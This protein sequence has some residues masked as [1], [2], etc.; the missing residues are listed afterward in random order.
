MTTAWVQQKTSL[1]SMVIIHVASRLL[2]SVIRLLIGNEDPALNSVSKSVPDLG[3]WGE[4]RRLCE[5][6]L[7]KASLEYMGFSVRAAVSH[8]RIEGSVFSDPCLIT[9]INNWY[10]LLEYFKLLSW[11]MLINI[12]LILIHPFIHLFNKCLLNYFYVW[13]IEI[14]PQESE[15]KKKIFSKELLIYPED[16][17]QLL[18]TKGHRGPE[19]WLG[20]MCQKPGWIREQV[21][22]HLQAMVTGARE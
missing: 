17:D 15:K 1:S 8:T 5:V 16:S 14:R 12:Y 11:Y 9:T 2:L 19:P 3:C 6:V 13:E 20:Q 22:A 10:I 18:Q 4:P 21:V 7:P